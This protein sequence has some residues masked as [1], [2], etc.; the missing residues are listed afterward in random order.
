MQKVT[1]EHHHICRRF[2][3][4][5]PECEQNQ[6]FHDQPR[7]KQEILFITTHSRAVFVNFAA[8]L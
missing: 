1:N 5:P 4:H 8:K 7:R 2:Y 3:L 6:H